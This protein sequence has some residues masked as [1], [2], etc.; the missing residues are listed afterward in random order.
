MFFLF[1]DTFCIQRF[2]P[3]F[4]FLDTFCIQRFFLFLDTFGLMLDHV[5]SELSA[6]GAK[7]LVWSEACEVNS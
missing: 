3:V 1:L 5:P 7:R 6:T 2:F 4:L